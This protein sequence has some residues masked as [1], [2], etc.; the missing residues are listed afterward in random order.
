MISIRRF[1]ETKAS[2]KVQEMDVRE[3]LVQ[4][5]QVLFEGVATHM[6]RADEQAAADLQRVF[7]TLGRQLAVYPSSFEIVNISSQALEALQDYQTRNTAFL[8]RR[9]QERQSILA[10]LTETVAV[11]SDQG[12]STVERLQGIEKQLVQVSALD[13]ISALRVSLDQCLREVRETAAQHRAGSAATVERL[14]YQL[15]C[16]LQNPEPAPS[17]AS[18]NVADLELVGDGARTSDSTPLTSY[19]GAFKLQSSQ[20]IASRFGEPARQQ[21]LNMIAKRLKALLGPDDRLLRWKGTAFVMFIRSASSLQ[22]VRTRLSEAIAAMREQYIEVGKKS[23]LLSV[24]VDWTVFRQ[25]EHPTLEAV[26]AEVDAFLTKTRRGAAWS[27][28]P[29]GPRNE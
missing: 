5:G 19:V 13:D 15:D 8:R 7:E 25:D 16:S 14:Q 24:G 6:V 22:E 23:A 18:F 9:S 29:A 4:M 11:L 26:F 12:D 1:L 3:A 10:M 21:M 20:H 2:A 17:S 28:G 27:G